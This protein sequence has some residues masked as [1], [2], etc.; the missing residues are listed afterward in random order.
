MKTVVYSRDFEELEIR[1][2]KAIDQY[3]ALMASEASARLTGS[4]V[5]SSRACPG[6]RADV[7]HTIFTKSG[8]SYVE[9]SQCRSVYVSPCPSDDALVAFYRESDAARFWRGPL[10]NETR[11]VRRSKVYRPRAE[12]TMEVLDRYLPDARLGLDVGYHSCAFVEEMI[13]GEGPLSDI[14]VANPVADIE[15]AGLDLAGVR[16]EPTLVSGIAEHGPVDVVFAFDILPCIFDVDA[17]L[18]AAHRSLT[19]GGLMLLNARLISGLDLQVLWDRSPDIT[20]PDRINL[21]SAEGL[22]KMAERQEFEVLE[23][24]T[25][26]MFDVDVVARAIHANPD[27][28]WPR[29]MR[30]LVENRSEQALRALQEY[31]QEHRLSSFARIALRLVT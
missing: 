31:L 18:D 23:F 20:P 28:D 2:K 30:Y 11:D 19:P 15:C 8:L 3:H 9:C 24:S 7:G 6:C 16:V 14:V 1:P 25:P 13:S 21:P 4:H 22:Q 27:A 5:T 26:G 17:L 12:W 29:F 10:W